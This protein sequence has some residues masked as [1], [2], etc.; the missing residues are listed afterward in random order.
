MTTSIIIAG[1]R[2]KMG[3]EAVNMVLEE[4]GY[5]LI[6]CLDHKNEGKTLA[7]IPGL[8]DMNVPI[9]TDAEKCFQDKQADILIDLTVPGVG[10]KHTE[11]ALNHGIRPVV[12]TSGFTSEQID[13]LSEISKETKTGCIIAPNFAIGAVLMMQFAKLAAV[14]LPDVEIIEKHH[15]QKVDAPSGTALKT[16]D[17]IKEARKS[18]IQGHPQEKENLPGARGAVD[19]GIHIHSVRLPG[20]VAHQEVIFGGPGQT[21]TITHDSLERKSFMSGIKLAIDHVK[22]SE[23]L[24]YGLEKIMIQQ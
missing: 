19:D 17:M 5:E 18:K 6:A 14:Y 15:D 21:L 1:P 23:E 11:M 4:K 2:G 10:Y 22:R 3:S 8:P 13:R 7:D 20:L 16:V 24:V 9:Y 12:G